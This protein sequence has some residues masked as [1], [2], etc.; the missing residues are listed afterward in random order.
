MLR[1]PR[2]EEFA[3]F[4]QQTNRLRTTSSLLDPE[5]V[6]QEGER[7]VDR[8]R[9]HLRPLS[10]GIDMP[11]PERLEQE[12]MEHLSPA[13]TIDRADPTRVSRRNR[14]VDP[15]EDRRPVEIETPAS[16]P[17]SDAHTL[18]EFA[19]PSREGRRHND[20]HDLTGG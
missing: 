2:V 10:E 12:R 9:R 6:F 19:T 13:S 18:Q 20:R 8:R 5:L 14:S 7:L 3:R 1:C 15:E 17:V 11:L 16:V 4:T